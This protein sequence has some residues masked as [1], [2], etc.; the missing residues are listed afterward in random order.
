MTAYKQVSGVAGTET[1]TMRELAFSV[2]LSSERFRVDG[3]E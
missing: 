1:V 3:L 2:L